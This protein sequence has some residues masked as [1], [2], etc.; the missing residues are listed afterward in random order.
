MKRLWLKYP[1]HGGF[2]YTQISC[3]QAPVSVACIDPLPELC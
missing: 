3:T 2:L 1:P